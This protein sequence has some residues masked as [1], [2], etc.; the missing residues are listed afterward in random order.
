MLGPREAAVAV[1]I[2]INGFGRTG[3]ALYRVI[4][5][6]DLPIEVVAVNDLGAP[7][8]LA[9]LLQRDSVHGRLGVALAVGED[10][11]VAGRQHTTV[12]GLADPTR[13]PWR[14]LGVDV[15]VECSG[16]LTTRDKA[17]AH[18]AAGAGRVIVSAPCS[19]ADATFVIGVNEGE[20]DPERHFV[21]SNA[22]CTTNCFA[23]MAKVLD[24]W[25]GIDTGF[26]TTI[27]AYTGDQALVDG[28]HKDA[29]RGRAAGLN[30]V[31]TSTGAARATGLVLPATEGSLDGVAVRVPVADGS[32]TDFVALLKR[33]VTVAEVNAAF[34]K[35]ASHDLAGL[36][37]YSDDSL[38]SSDVVGSSASCV[39]DAPLTMAKGSLVKTFGWYDNE[40]GYS[41]RLADLATLVGTAR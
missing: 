2:G 38:V 34:A 21:V 20:F 8:Q 14:D 35:A 7:E 16:K 39:F 26:M 27:H 29:R 41:S 5:E 15:V 4:V 25:F 17:A 30:I 32:L 28:L 19:G 33:E 9:R 12:L 13:L 6:G 36:L 31:P 18:L 3:R 23:L 37:D 22:S 24:S 11:I 40:W 10:Q 1:R